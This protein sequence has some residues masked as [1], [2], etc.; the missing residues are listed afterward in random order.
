MEKVR[1]TERTI[2]H[3]HHEGNCASSHFEEVV[4]VMDKKGTSI[5]YVH[6][7]PDLRLI[8]RAPRMYDLLL[9]IQEKV[10]TAGATDVTG[11]KNLS[12]QTIYAIMSDLHDLTKPLDG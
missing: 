1:W 11:W 6:E 7:V 8:L 2:A 3:L 10:H 9:R 4:E 12:P 5:A